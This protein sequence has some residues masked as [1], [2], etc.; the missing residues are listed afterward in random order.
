[1]K[2]K[3]EVNVLCEHTDSAEIK[4]NLRECSETKY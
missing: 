4:K 3:E 2:K 1:M